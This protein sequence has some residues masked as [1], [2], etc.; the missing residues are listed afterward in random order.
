MKTKVSEK[1]QITVPKALRDRLG[2]RAGDELDMFE[3]DGILTALKVMPEDPV[4]S[5]YGTVRL[6]R[7]TDEIIRELRGDVDLP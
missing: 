7:S 1:G 4:D 5:V 3:N 2:L 6:G